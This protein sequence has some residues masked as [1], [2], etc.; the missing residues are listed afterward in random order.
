[1]SSRDKTISRPIVVDQPKIG[2]GESPLLHL[3]ENK[4]KYFRHI[5]LLHHAITQ[6]DIATIPMARSSNRPVAMCSK[7]CVSAAHDAYKD[8]MAPS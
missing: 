2:L 3:L 5:C 8:F 1:M 6:A 7:S 4:I